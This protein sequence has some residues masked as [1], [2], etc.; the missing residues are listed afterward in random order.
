MSNTGP[1]P[2]VPPNPDARAAAAPQYPALGDYEILG[3]LG[4]G[5]MGVVYR[6]RQR[7]LGRVVALKMILSGDRASAEELARFRREAAVVAR[8]QHPNIVQIYAVS[9]YEG[10]PYFSLEFVDGGTLADRLRTGRP[11]PEQAAALAQ[12]LARAL[13]AVHQAGIVHRDLKPANVLLAR[14]DT[15]KL[16][17][18]GL[19][20]K[21]D[22]ESAQTQPGA[23][24]G[25]PSYMA[26]EQAQGAAAQAT[27]AADVYGLGAILYECLTGRPPLQGAT[28]VETL[29]LVAE[30]EPVAPRALNPAVP[31][32]LNTICL[33]CLEKTPE[34]RYATAGEL[35]E[36]L[37]R[38]LA[39]E[40][41]R[42]RPVGRV[43]RAALWLRRHRA[44]TAAVLALALAATAS[45]WLS[46]RPSRDVGPDPLPLDPEKRSELEKAVDE[47]KVASW[48]AP[49]GLPGPDLPL[50][51]REIDALWDLANSREG[52]R[53][54][55]VEL[56]LREARTTR[57][58]RNTRRYALH[59]AVGLDHERRAEVERLLLERLQ[60]EAVPAGQKADLAVALTALGG[61]R[62][63]AVSRVLSVIVE[64]MRVETRPEELKTL[65]EALSA[66]APRLQ[67]GDAA[68][69]A[70]ALIQAI[71]E[72]K[73]FPFELKAVLSA[74]AARL[75][76]RGAA[77][78]AEFLVLSFSDFREAPDLSAVAA[79]LEP[80][81]AAAVADSVIKMKKGAGDRNALMLQQVALSA[82]AAGLDAR[83]GAAVANTLLRALKE[84][85]NPDAQPPWDA[86][87]WLMQVLMLAS[88]R[89]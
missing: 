72:G 11:H 87:R 85:T 3:E 20:R 43:G 55:F 71:K 86:R 2:E 37:G 13:H 49:L 70:D 63:E 62:P 47:D 27:P 56:A 60:V 40:P 29:R 19:A 42:A 23:V 31:R 77:K 79:R 48:L 35:A 53:H 76:S 5:A 80:G 88:A 7:A 17:D 25:T 66:L 67:P 57:Q 16:T 46:V 33:K 51:D 81:D 9:E 22:G 24:V 52:M 36:D 89:K 26:P 78:A 65:G 68:T 41:I 28:P 73:G 32:D 1:S 34:R 54:R 64:A 61:L 6:A 83:A 30:E 45:A 50:N 21:L 39:R 44:L 12:A 59:A 14:D 15:P 82:L 75:N 38:F 69:A 18:F 10:R 74:M 58:L 8:L 4:R 84:P